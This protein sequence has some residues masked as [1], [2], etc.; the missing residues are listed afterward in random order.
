M[1]YLKMVPENHPWTCWSVS[2]LVVFG[3]TVLPG[4]AQVDWLGTAEKY[5]KHN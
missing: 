3:G 5:G 2:A 4:V 1:N